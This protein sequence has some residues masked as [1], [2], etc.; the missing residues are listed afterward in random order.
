MF[1]LTPAIELGVA[2]S[3]ELNHYPHPTQP[4][5]DNTPS[6]LKKFHNSGRWDSMFFYHIDNLLDLVEELNNDQLFLAVLSLHDGN[7]LSSHRLKEFMVDTCK[8]IL[9]GRRTV[10]LETWKILLEDTASYLSPRK[11]NEIN[12][13]LKDYSDS[14]AR[15]RSCPHEHVSTTYISMWCE[16]LGGVRDLAFSAMFI[17]E[18]IHRLMNPPKVLN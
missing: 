1:K 4:F 10:P 18:T 5:M 11:E 16:K 13:V 17:Y 2:L 12:R 9:T 6:V 3:G 8:F 7:A 15:Q 14:I